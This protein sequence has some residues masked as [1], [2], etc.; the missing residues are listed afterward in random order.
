MA[1][2]TVARRSGLAPHQRDEGPNPRRIVAVD[3]DGVLADTSG[4]FLERLGSEYGIELTRKGLTTYRLADNPR[5]PRGVA[6]GL[7]EWFVLGGAGFAEPLPG[8]RAGVAR[9][10][11]KADLFYWTSRDVQ[12][13]R[14]TLDWLQRHGFPSAPL[15]IAPSGH[16]GLLDVA[17]DVCIDDDPH[18]VEYFARRGRRAFLFLHPWTP[19]E[20]AEN[21]KLITPVVSWEDI[22]YRMSALDP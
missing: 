5:V 17:F 1:Q 4:L 11:A 19:L 21:R 16:K 13:R 20:A 6:T 8:A 18:V 22:V 7:R 10:M 12:L 14:R 2:D 9:V 3:V 15:L